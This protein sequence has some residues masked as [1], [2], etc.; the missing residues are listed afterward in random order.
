MRWSRRSPLV[1]VR[2]RQRCSLGSSR[3]VRVERDRPRLARP[4]Q[5][6]EDRRKEPAVF[7][8]ISHA[9]LLSMIVALAACT[10]STLSPFDIVR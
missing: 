10:V 6:A 7:D 4:L 1:A 5:F 3:T 9:A 8:A 2:S